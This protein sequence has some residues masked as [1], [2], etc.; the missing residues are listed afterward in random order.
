MKEKRLVVPTVN[1][2]HSEDETGLSIKVD[3]TGAQKNSVDLEMR[4][5]GFCVKAEGE[6]VR[7][8]NCYRLPHEVIP[9]ETN[10]RFESGILTIHAPFTGMSGGY[11]VPID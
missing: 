2:S 8:E 4:K 6:D 5:T 11:K 3:L 7:Y 9:E 10:A 1:I